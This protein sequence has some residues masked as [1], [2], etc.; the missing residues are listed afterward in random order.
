M[1]LLDIE[2]LDFDVESGIYEV[3]LLVVENNKIIESIHIAEVE[4]ESL[5]HLGMGNGYSDISEDPKKIEQFRSVIDT[6]NY[7]VIA[8]NVAFDRKFLVHYG[9]LNED[10]EC[11]DSIRAI[12]YS[13]PYLFSYSLGYLAN[14]F[15]VETELSHIAL[16]DVKVLYEVIMK[17]NPTNWVPLYKISPRKF[18]QLVE[19]TVSVEGQSSIF[20]NKTIVFTGAS[21]FPRALMKE[22]VSKCSAKVTSSVSP[23]TDLL[24]CGENPGSKLVKARELGVEV[25]TDEWFIDAVS[26]ELDLDTATMTHHKTGFKEE[27][28]P[29]FTIVPELNGKSVNIALLPIK[30]QSKL[31]DILI[32]N[33]NVSK[34]NKSSNGY[35]VDLIIHADNG[36]Y[37]LLEKAKELEVDTMPL[38]KFNQMILN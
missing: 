20:E 18:K 6:Y 8:H 22:I 27:T 10:Y 4:D 17:A 26:K 35:K 9:W 24:I 29:Q 30:I 16:D 34:V 14:F 25:E 33:M 37:V 7:P 1:I 12:K 19:T 36:E 38:S 3:A 5:I 2:T 31:E 32:N 28:K 13:N 23:K 15:N 11:Y 21:Q